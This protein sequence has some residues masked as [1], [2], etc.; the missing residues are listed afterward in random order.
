MRRLLALVKKWFTT[1]HGVCFL[2]ILGAG[3]A[4]VAPLVIEKAAP[5]YFPP[6]LSVPS[7]GATPIID[8]DQTPGFG[9]AHAIRSV[10]YLE[11]IGHEEGSMLWDPGEFAG[12]PFLAE[13]NT[14]ALSPFSLPIYLFGAETG[15][16][17]A[18]LIKIFVAGALAFYVARV[19]GFTHPFALLI[20]V[21]HALNAS[22][23]VWTADPVSD[24]VVWVP[25]IFL[26]AERLSLGQLRY[27]PAASILI[28][29]MLLSGAPQ[30]VA[31]TL[32]FFGAY[33][34]YRRTQTGWKGV[35]GA[36]VSSTLALALG[37]GIAG[38][39]IVPWL[40]WL[41]LSRAV[42]VPGDASGWV[43]L[44]APLGPLAR[45]EDLQDVRAIAPLHTGYVSLLL[46]LLW[47]VVRPQA[48]DAQKRRIDALLI[49]STVW[50]ATAIV[51]S[52]V[53]PFA[54][55]LQP[56]LIRALVA[57]LSFGL[58]LGG[59]AAA[60]AWLQLR[61][62][63]SLAAIR[64]YGLLL[65]IFTALAVVSYA[66]GWSRMAGAPEAFLQLG[67]T[68]ASLVVFALVLGITLV[69]P[70]PRLMGYSL[71]AIT[72][73]ELLALF[74]P[75]QPRTTW[76][77]LTEGPFQTTARHASAGR[78][79]FGPGTD[80]AG[81]M[82]IESP[83]IRGFGPRAPARVA[84]FLERARQDP[85]LYTRAGVSRFVLSLADVSGPY[86]RLRP[87]LRLLNVTAEGA[88][89]FEYT[90]GA[91]PTRLLH[92]IN[93]VRRFDPS[94]LDSKLVSQVEAAAD[95]G[96]DEGRPGRPLLAPTSRVEIQRVNVFRNDPG[97]L[98]LA[99]TNYPDWTARV[100]NLSAPIFPVDGA[101]QGI[102]LASGSREA[103]FRY[104]PRSFRWGLVVS[105]IALSLSLLGLAHLMYSRLQNQYFKM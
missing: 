84:A 101:F 41:Q 70:W 23:I 33:Y 94:L 55:V 8:N 52:C 30:A 39:Q 49:I 80:T 4:A 98:V 27:W 67:A 66:M 78:I 68:A 103:V 36:L 44:L 99:Q 93:V 46:A 9:A 73:L 47:L 86:A 5:V 92:D 35:P 43:A 83:L 21:L 63:Q 90:P 3:I 38:V 65:A 20:A 105:C 75:L 31:S 76:A 59:A 24:A 50:L 91:Q 48:P 22:L 42:W 53:Q 32:V 61:P 2:L 62:A 1:E 71:C 40:E 54:E 6:T 74:V 58:A 102:E 69:R 11:Q 34:I 13:W 15:L 72:A 19:L 79:A 57:P 51:L 28:G 104:A 12:T 56:I 85:L 81:R 17:V 25:M 29:L 26:F 95:P 18:A 89:L 14:R 88:G 60:E 10:L 82:A 16:W 97:V 45:P 64:R 87:Q 37:I 7:V 77:D 100:D 96:A